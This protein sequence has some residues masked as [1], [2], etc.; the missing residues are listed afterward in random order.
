MTKL[1]FET[2]WHLHVVEIIDFLGN[3]LTLVHNDFN[4]FLLNN[5]MSSFEALQILRHKHLGQLDCFVASKGVLLLFNLFFEVFLGSFN[6]GFR[7]P[8]DKLVI[9]FS[10]V[11]FNGVLWEEHVKAMLVWLVSS[12]NFLLESL[13]VSKNLL[14][15]WLVIVYQNF[16]F[17]EDFLTEG[18][19]SMRVSHEKLP[20]SHNNLWRHEWSNDVRAIGFVIQL[21]GLD[22]DFVY[23]NYVYFK[24]LDNFVGRL[25]V[26]SFSFV[27]GVFSGKPHGECELRILA[28]VKIVSHDLLGFLVDNVLWF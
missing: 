10:L 1:I 11:L 21:V 8:S 16:T 22:E 15:N 28:H 7:H 9:D 24:L 25:E 14:H 27:T 2:V 19:V 5:L 12:F 26:E 13:V 23:S 18:H 20:D 17:S 4:V 3:I 6:I